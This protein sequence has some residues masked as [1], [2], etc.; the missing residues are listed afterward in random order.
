MWCVK[1][2]HALRSWSDTI[3]LKEKV[4]VK[5]VQITNLK[6]VKSLGIEPCHESVKALGMLHGERF[7]HLQQHFS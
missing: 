4:K 5:R 3:Q 1:G 6:K 2:K 7:S